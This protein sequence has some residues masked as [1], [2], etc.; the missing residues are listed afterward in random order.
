ML[1]L[2]KTAIMTSL[3]LMCPLYLIA[4]ENPDIS[5]QGYN[6]ETIKQFIS[7]YKNRLE[8]MLSHSHEDL[9]QDFTKL[10]QVIAPFL[11][12]E[13]VRKE[14]LNQY[15]P[16][17]DQLKIIYNQTKGYNEVGNYISGLIVYALITNEAGDMENAYKINEENKGLMVMDYVINEFRNTLKIKTK[18]KNAEKVIPVMENKIINPIEEYHSNKLLLCA[19]HPDFEKI[20]KQYSNYYNQT[21]EQWYAVDYDE[22]MNPDMQGDLNNPQTYKYLGKKKFNIVFAENCPNLVDD[23]VRKNAASLLNPSGILVSKFCGKFKDIETI[24]MEMNKAGFNQVIFGEGGDYWMKYVGPKEI[25]HTFKRTE[26]KEAYPRGI[27]TCEKSNG[28]Q[29]QVYSFVAIK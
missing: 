4:M 16:F 22:I 14:I 28:T 8:K 15:M 5:A 25:I 19:G 29:A 24:K 27:N 11:Q 13:N 2:K 18:T 26:R 6:E 1:N 23:E 12:D 10:L 20:S 3:I 7:K 21:N 17:L 9:G